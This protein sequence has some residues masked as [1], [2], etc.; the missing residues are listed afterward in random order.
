MG[1]FSEKD[2]ILTHSI[3][4]SLGYNSVKIMFHIILKEY[5]GK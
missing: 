4:P 2:K 5:E 1:Q 3:L